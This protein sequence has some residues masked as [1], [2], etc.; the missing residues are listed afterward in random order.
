M[1]RPRALLDPEIWE[2]D[3]ARQQ[4]SAGGMG[5]GREEV[6]IAAGERERREKGKK[7]VVKRGGKGKKGKREKKEGSEMGKG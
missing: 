7:L 5:S 3:K 1:R 6:E 4:Q 2:E